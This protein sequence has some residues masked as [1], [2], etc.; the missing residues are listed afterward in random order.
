MIEAIPGQQLATATSA[1]LVVSIGIRGSEEIWCSGCLGRALG[2]EEGEGVTE[3]RG[4]GRWREEKENAGGWKR[5][6]RE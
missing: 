3:R 5:E 1:V 2:R 6:E 4:R